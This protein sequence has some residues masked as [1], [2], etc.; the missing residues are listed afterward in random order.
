MTK[1]QMDSKPIV[2][3]YESIGLFRQYLATT[4]GKYLFFKKSV[5]PPFLFHSNDFFQEV[6]QREL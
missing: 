2:P 1:F 6:L 3:E 4:I 5:S